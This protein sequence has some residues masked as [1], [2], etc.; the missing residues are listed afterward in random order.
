MNIKTID[1]LTG[2]PVSKIVAQILHTQVPYLRTLVFFDSLESCKDLIFEFLE[3]KMLW[4]SLGENSNAWAWSIE[5]CVCFIFG[6]V[7]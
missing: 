7:C 2:P 3:K 1:V 5:F 6:T 4:W